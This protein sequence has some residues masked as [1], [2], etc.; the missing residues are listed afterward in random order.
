MDALIWI[1]SS[2]GQRVL[3]FSIKLCPRIQPRYL[4]TQL[5]CNFVLC[6][7]RYIA[8]KNPKTSG[9]KLRVVSRHSFPIVPAVHS[10][11][12]NEVFP[13]SCPVKFRK[14]Y[15]CL[16]WGHHGSLAGVWDLPDGTMQCGLLNVVL[17]VHLWSILNV[18]TVPSGHA[19]WGC[20]SDPLV[21]P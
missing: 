3:V 16:S 5:C 9:R 4:Y 13:L 7:H 6:T 11:H 19:H 15:P 21:S 10:R 1:H 17:A 2:C 8:W 18:L 12:I 14:P 20:L